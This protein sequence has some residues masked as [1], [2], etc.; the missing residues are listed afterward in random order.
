MADIV[1]TEF[2]D[3]ESVSSL[4]GDFDV[5]YDPTLVDARDRL[6]S[7]LTTARALVVRNR[8]RVDEA[9]VSSAPR[10]EVVGRLGVG[11]DNIDLVA[12]ERRGVAVCPATGANDTAVAEYVIAAALL[13]RRP[14][15]LSSAS[16]A[17]GTWPRE[18][19]IGREIAG[20]TMGL[21]GY[22][23]TAREVARRARDLGMSVQVFDPYLAQDAEL[24]DVHRTDRLDDL[25]RSSDVVSLHVPLTDSTR[26][27]IDS[28]ALQ[29]LR[30]DA[31]LVNT[32]R[33][34]VVDEDAL[35]DSLRR[36]AIRGAALDVFADEPLTGERAARFAGVPNL[37][38]TPH[39]AGVTSESN[40][41][42]GLATAQ[43]VRR[44]LNGM[45]R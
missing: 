10:L 32:A 43:N 37:V 31:V 24:N 44:V 11:L 18:T 38:L 28:D 27:L 29:Q 16:V 41:R 8:T 6:E 2:M 23:A 14:V 26:G 15:F 17:S 45:A 5:V 39:V 42:V 4:A 30:E 40:V 9:L 22:G 20:A 36:G 1:I 3:D 35:V 19:G 34:H 12:C 21:V 7:L 33:G 13:L 25:L